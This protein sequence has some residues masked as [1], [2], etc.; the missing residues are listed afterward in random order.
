MK[1]LLNLACFYLLIQNLS[2]QNY[3]EQ[4]ASL[5]NEKDTT[6]V[7]EL[8]EKWEKEKPRDAELYTSY[9]NYYFQ[10]SKTEILNLSTNPDNNDENSMKITDSLGNTKGYLGSK[11]F[12]EKYYTQKAFEYIDKGISLFPKRL[13]MR[14]GKIHALRIIKDW[15]VF[16]T[17]IL[18]TIDYSAKVKQ[19][20]TWTNNVDAENPEKLFFG[21]IQDYVVTLYNTEDDSLLINMRKISERILKY[22]PEDVPSYSNIA[23]TY[24]ILAEFDKAIETLQKAE[25]IAPKDLVIL[26]NLARTYVLKEDKENAIL[27]YQKMVTYGNKRDKAYAEEQIEKLKN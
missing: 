7:R 4:F 22:Y 24:M 26:N 2:A 21:S 25:K 17:E 9:F 14:F 11:V 8:L 19:K 23:V 13:D 16:T 6:A 1:I 18:K 15:E 12:F 20:W 27:Y 10:K 5:I 3:Q